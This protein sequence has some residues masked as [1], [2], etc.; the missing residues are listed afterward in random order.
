[1]AAVGGIWGLVLALAG[2]ALAAWM[3]WL[4]A[5]LR[6]IA[7]EEARWLGLAGLVLFGTLAAV[8]G[9]MVYAL[10]RRERDLCRL[11][12]LVALRGEA[13]VTDA[14]SPSALPLPVSA[15]R[16][17]GA[18]IDE[19]RRER[20]RAQER[21]RAAVE[22]ERR[23]LAAILRDLA[24]GLVVCAP[25]GRILLY[26]D[27]ARRILAMPPA[28]GLGR[29]LYRVLAAP[30]LLHQLRLLR[31]RDPDQSAPPVSDPFLC[32]T[33][34]GTR[35]LRCRLA[36]VGETQEAAEGFVL[37]FEDA[38][39]LLVGTDVQR[40]LDRL[41]DGW[42]GPLLGLRAALERICARQERAGE[43][44]ADLCRRAADQQDRLERELASLV[45]DGR[46]FILAHWPLSEI[47]FRDL[48]AQVAQR[49]DAEG[50]AVQVRPPA[51][52][53]WLQA[54]GFALAEI[55]A[56]FCRE[57]HARF[58]VERF[59]LE[60][61]PERQQVLL[62]LA[63][64]GPAPDW[65]SSWLDRPLGQALR[66]RPRELLARHGCRPW[67]GAAEGGR[68]ALYLP[69]PPAPRP[70]RERDEE[71]LPP[72]P[73]FYDFALPHAVSGPLQAR[74]LKQASFCVLDIET[75]GLD[76]DRDDI[77]QLAAVRV[78]NGRILRGEIFDAL[79][80]PGRPIPPSSTRFH[81]IDDAMV[82]GKPPPAVVV[83]RF[84]A[85]AAEDV[86]VAHNA[87]FDLAF[88][89][90]YEAAAGVRFDQP[91]L[92]TLLLAAA[93][94]EDRDDHSL[95]ALAGR[96][97]V[98]VR[99]R[100]TALGDSFTTAEVLLRLLPLLAARGIATVGEALEAC[101]RA[102]RVRRRLAEPRPGWGGDGL[103]GP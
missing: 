12:D 73:E 95:E 27:A 11:L 44:R 2:A 79:V 88:L 103:Q 19:L 70:E 102:A 100:H 56:A 14:A 41:E 55:L 39:G 43:E 57:L 74:P 58:G 99:G 52:R 78:V 34:E 22:G 92:D 48:A 75:T 18:H 15:L 25:D 50:C 86:L 64:S 4:A 7:P 53:I 5:R 96:L 94:E 29:S 45:E 36:L 9:T 32:P 17:L 35:Y 6:P 31:T 37:V 81:G 13:A 38:T 72:R 40:F 30:P 77:V 63:W 89:R 3:W 85:F 49:L 71:R 67:I 28:L 42:R 26:N 87:A 93:L 60:A 51:E 90:K 54:D 69:L 47:E 68:R 80:D 59:D 23:R 46:R 21:A 83:A 97:G 76:P 82:R 24:E 98:E 84:H 91:V 20:E 8:A 62:L 1:M 101:A 10:R 61:R 33:A 16:R 65:F 66:F